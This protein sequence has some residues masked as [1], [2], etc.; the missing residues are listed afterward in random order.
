MAAKL[1]G[2]ASVNGFSTSLNGA[3]TGADE[4]ITLTTVTG[5]P[6]GGGIFVIDRI[7]AAGVATPTTREYVSYAAVA[8][9]TVTGAGRGLA[10]STAQSHSSGA[11]VEEVW[12]VTHVLDLIEFLQVSHDS[13]GNTLGPTWTD[14]SDGATITFNLGSGASTKQRVVLGGNRILALSN[15]RSGQVFMLRLEQDATGSRTVT[16]FDT[17]RWAGGSAPTLTTTASKADLFG[18]I[19]TGTDTYDG[20]VVMQNV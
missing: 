14:A 16:W 17:I 2:V 10:G 19:Q 15:V 20:C 3:I 8:G 1:H 18:F 11:I 12:S 6:T 7:D 13:S 5:L 9:S 4:V